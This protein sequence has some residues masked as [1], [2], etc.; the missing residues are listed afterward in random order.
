MRTH[1]G[2][3]SYHCPSSTKSF[4]DLAQ[5]E[6]QLKSHDRVKSY[7]CFKCTKAFQSKCDL[8]IHS[9]EHR[10]FICSI[11]NQSF[12]Y[13]SRLKEHTMTH[14]GERPFNCTVCTKS[15]IQAGNL[16]IH[17][18]VHSEEKPHSCSFSQKWLLQGHQS[19]H[20]GEKIYSCSICTKSFAYITD[21]NKH[22]KLHKK[23]GLWNV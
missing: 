19:V 17:F 18:W 15:S 23:R 1:T 14:T 8:K 7:N 16:N 4:S 5:R 2:E 10:D 9:R 22:L 12:C 3:L 21:L 11:C 6:K 20:T 13:P